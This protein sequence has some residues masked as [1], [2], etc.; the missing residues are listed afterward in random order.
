MNN[1]DTNALKNLSEAEILK[2]VRPASFNAFKALQTQYVSPLSKV[3]T[4]IE[5][6]KCKLLGMAPVLRIEDPQSWLRVLQANVP[7]SISALSAFTQ[8]NYLVEYL[9]NNGGVSVFEND[10]R[11]KK[12]IS[13]PYFE[14]STQQNYQAITDYLGRNLGIFFL[15][16]HLKNDI[17]NLIT[18]LLTQH[19]KPLD[20]TRHTQIIPNVESAKHS[21]QSEALNSHY[22]LICESALFAEAQALLESF[23]Q[24]ECITL[25]EDTLQQGAYSIAA[26]FET[27][28]QSEKALLSVFKS[29]TP[30]CFVVNS[31]GRIVNDF[32]KSDLHKI[33]DELM[34]LYAH[35]S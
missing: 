24:S 1:I 16:T 17:F 22:L 33:I 25:I 32:T 10:Y 11:A 12:G 30:L 29:A 27:H 23:G 5:S 21:D 19:A 3:N 4:D 2:T 6:L 13:V 15:Q 7:K 18:T 35:E 26:R 34:K 28:Y 9:D 14:W 8:V 31:A 20:Q